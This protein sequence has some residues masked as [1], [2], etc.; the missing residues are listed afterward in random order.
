M[1]GMSLIEEY[2]RQFPWRDWGRALALCPITRGQQILDLGCGPGDLSAMLAARGVAV[3]GIDRDPELLAAAR[4][5][6]PDIHFEQQDLSKL[7]LPTSFDG[8]W[9]SF[10]AAYFVD[11]TT[12]FARWCTLLKP[13]AW[14]CL[15]DIDDLLG[16]EPRSDATR[17]SIERF[18]RD[19]LQKRRYDFRAG[20]RLP[21][22]LEAQGFRVTTAELADSELAL[23]GPASPEV[24]TA[25]RARFSRMAGLKTFLG[26]EFDDFTGSFIGA[27]ESPQHRAL[28]KVVCCV[29][30]RD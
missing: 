22:T 8:I 6:A 23:D 5:R 19:A 24:L 9:C 3:T 29:G 14:V 15:I 10:T 2:R 26:S 13:S 7:T 4:A 12:T 28:C 1:R 17:D 30:R 20:Q 25:W 21:S 16:H 27:L 18:Y 11:F